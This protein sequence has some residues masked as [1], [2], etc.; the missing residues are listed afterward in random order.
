[1]NE[2]LLPNKTSQTE[3]VVIESNISKAI[4]IGEKERVRVSIN[5]QQSEFQLSLSLQQVAKM[6]RH[7]GLG[8]QKGFLYFALHLLLIH[9]FSVDSYASCR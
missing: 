2:L 9:S 3:A 7:S 8:L 4:N 5:Q 1:M 6:L